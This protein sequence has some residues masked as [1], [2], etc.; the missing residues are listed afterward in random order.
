MVR[1]L[2]R[3]P[4]R[5]R[6]P[7]F[8]FRRN[9]ARFAKTDRQVQR[10]TI[11]DWEIHSV[12]SGMFR[13]DGGAMFGVVPRNLWAKAAPPDD[14]NRISM[15][16]RN[17]VARR[18]GRTVVVDTG[19]GIGYGEKLDRIYAFESALPPAQGLKP[20]GLRPEDVTDVI[21]THLHFDHA[22]GAAVP[23]P[24]GYTLAFPNAVHH[25]Q[26]TQWEHAHQPNP[27]DRASYF[28]ER[29][30]VIADK[31]ALA[32]HEGDWSLAAGLDV[33]TFDGHTPGQH[34]PLFSGPKDALLFCGDLVPTAAHFPAA[35]V[36]AYDLDPV[37]SMDEKSAILSRSARESWV[38]LFEHDPNVAA[39]SVRHD[40]DR[41]RFGP[42]DII[43]V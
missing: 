32:L 30:D 27:R 13:L 15:A 38:L 16:M 31:G 28:R 37:R 18:P 14:E 3:P 9:A 21:I 11:G 33:I 6:L 26:R 17:L 29:I 20:L 5:A 1:G 40:S 39:C 42:R 43:V 34:L 23:T 22:G 12:I 36:M 10:M 2:A 41:D 35:Y 19:A 24:D 8:S 7:R 25:V 4:R